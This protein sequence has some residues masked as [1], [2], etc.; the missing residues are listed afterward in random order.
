[1]TSADPTDPAVPTLRIDELSIDFPGAGTVVDSVSFDVRPGEVVALVGESGSGKSVTAKAIL[2]LLPDTA[3]SSGSVQVN[4]DEVLGLDDAQLRAVRGARVAMV[5]QEPGTA[6][7]PVEKVGWQIGEALRAHRKI[8]RREARARAVELLT[9]VE[10]PDPETRVDH[11]PHQLSGGQ[12]Q[13][14]VIALALANE[15]D[16]IIAD[17]PTT[18]LDVTV[19]AEILTLLHDLRARLGRA[20]LL[21]THNMGVVADLADRVIVLRHGVVVESDSADAVFSR[22]RAAYTKELLAAVPK[23][24]PAVSAAA[25]GISATD[26][27]VDFAQ[28]VVEYPGRLGQSAFTAIHEVDLSVTRGEVLGLV[29]ESGSG[30]STLGRVA[31]GLMKPKAGRATVLGQEL[32]SLSRSQLRDVRRRIGMVFQDP[33]ASLDPLRSVGDAISEPIEVHGLARGAELRARVVA[34]L[35]SVHLPASY[36]DRRP[37][38]LSGG[39][40]QRVGLARALALDPELVVADEPTSALDV[41]VQ[42]RVLDLFGELRERFGFACLFISH[43]LAVVDRVADRVAVLREGSVVEVGEPATVL[44]NPATEYTRHLIDAVP[45]PDPAIQRRKRARVA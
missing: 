33:A 13:R 14:V 11:Y 39:Q 37:V 45:A 19:Q 30:K 1:M 36:A 2:G 23:L 42:A 40:R 8:S 9:L 29:G 7:N 3:T 10:I 17:E 15:P 27:V 18:A 32:S 12:R 16:L 25:A 26:A 41:V 21:I 6:L 5:F 4:G 34:L 20:V 31:V 43:D 35:E 38:E 44:R 28:L 22:P 24:E